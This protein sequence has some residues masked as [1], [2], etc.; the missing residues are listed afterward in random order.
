MG[1]RIARIIDPAL[2]GIIALVTTASLFALYGKPAESQA[3]DRPEAGAKVQAPGDYVVTPAIG[4]NWIRQIGIPDFRLT[5]MGEMGGDGPPPSSPRKE[6]RFSVEAAPRGGRNGMGMGGMMGPGYAAPQYSR[7][8]LERMMGEKF[9][10]S[11]SDLYRLDCQ[12]CHGPSGKGA[13]PEIESLV[14]P[15]QGTSPALVEKRMEDMGRPIG[16]KMAKELASQSEESIRQ[17]LRDGGEKMPPFRHLKGEEV[18]ALMQYIKEQVGAPEAQGKELLVSESVARVGEHLVKGTCQICHDA[19]GPGLGRMGMM[20]GIIPSLASFPSEQSMEKIV[21][22]VELGT[23]GMMMG[24]RRMPAYP[25]IT[26][27]EA[28]AAYLYLVQYP[29][30]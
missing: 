26:P 20:S 28:A 5:S 13:P 27:D 22:Q 30:Y 24:G 4:P 25:Y 9:L 18:K 19:T 2:I 15:F 23:R 6:P 7:S 3:A 11:G 17:W 14:G 29:P 12:S 21:W 1:V 16:E 10:L 8:E